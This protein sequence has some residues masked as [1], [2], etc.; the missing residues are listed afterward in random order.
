MLKGGKSAG[1]CGGAQWG[2]GKRGD[3]KS[4][5]GHTRMP[6]CISCAL[7]FSYIVFVFM[8]KLFVPFLGLAV[9]KNFR[10]PTGDVYPLKA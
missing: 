10:M 1:Q 7:Y 6:H 3:C 2:S 9:L 8:L 4:V 5:A